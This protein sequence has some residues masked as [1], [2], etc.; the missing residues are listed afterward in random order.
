MCVD[1]VVK[2]ADRLR[3]AAITVA[4]AQWRALGWPGTTEKRARAI[5]D[6]EALILVSHLLGASERRLGTLLPWWASVGSRLLSVQRMKNLRSRF[7][8]RMGQL[9]AEFARTAVERGKDLRWRPSAEGKALLP[10][11]KDLGARPTLADPAA[12]MLRLRSGFGV[13]IKAD[14]L[15]FLLGIHGGRATVQHIARAT[16]YYERAVRRALEE[17]A[18]ARLVLPLQTAPASYRTDAKLWAP[19]LGFDPDPPLWR[20]WH[21]TFAFVAQALDLVEREVAKGSSA[22]VIS[23]RA[24]DLME[25]QGPVLD[26]SVLRIPIEDRAGEEYLEVF[27]KVLEELTEYMQSVC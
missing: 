23:S 17:M 20:A 13:G 22:Y 4:W 24:R 19:V 18:V 5:V 2:A 15:A 3:E 8:E 12:L 10:R 27:A 6:P 25:R 9:L 16:A 1:L 26:E 7:P 14:V 11:S 21:V